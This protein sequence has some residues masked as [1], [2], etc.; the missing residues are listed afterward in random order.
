MPMSD[1]LHK[2]PRVAAL[3]QQTDEV[4]EGASIEDTPHNDAPSPYPFASYAAMAAWRR[5]RAEIEPP[6][7]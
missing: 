1:W 6:T 2:Y 4:L 7:A 3:L 5:R